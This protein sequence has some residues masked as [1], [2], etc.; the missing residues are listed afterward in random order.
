MARGRLFTLDTREGHTKVQNDRE[1]ERNL[2]ILSR[3]FWGE[4]GTV[5][6]GGH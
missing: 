2:Y 4:A 6:S 3:S 1:Q 5:N